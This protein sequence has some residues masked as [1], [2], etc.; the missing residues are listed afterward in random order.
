MIV[1]HEENAPTMHVP[2]PCKR[3][4]KVLFSPILHKECPNIAVGMTIL[5]PGGVS[6]EHAHIEGEM[7]YIVAGN[8]RITADGDSIT[9]TPGT[10]IWSPPGERHQLI[11]D[12]SDTLKILW[13][14]NPP[15]REAN[16]LQNADNSVVEQE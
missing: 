8:G 2:E 11:N 9:L 10:A 4:L 14:L 6:D 13:A 12:G 15:G 7:F 3:T 1:V 16:I 5:P